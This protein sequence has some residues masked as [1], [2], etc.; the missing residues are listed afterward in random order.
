MDAE[1]VTG[2]DIGTEVD[3]GNR[4]WLWRLGLVVEVEAGC[5]CRLRLGEEAQAYLEAEAGCR[6]PPP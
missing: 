5:I 3:C 4:G 1:A 6:C 2:L